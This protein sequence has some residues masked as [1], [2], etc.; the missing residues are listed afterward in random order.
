[1]TES[2]ARLV[3]MVDSPTDS[4]DILEAYEEAVFEQASFFMRRVF[5]PKLAKA[6]VI[7]LEKIELAAKVLALNVAS[8]V[9]SAVSFDFDCAKNHQDVLEVY[10]LAEMKI[11]L[12]L[13]NS[14]SASEAIAAFHSWVGLFDAYMESFLLLCD[15]EDDDSTVKLTV[16][17]IFVEFKN[18]TEQEKLDLIR[19]EC[20]RL[21]RLRD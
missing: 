3:L 15:F 11:K 2:E 5:I 4:E 7:K 18:S 9:F 10:N 6:R 13:A 16:A 20:A 17:P 14:S 1:M 12:V 8:K 21:K 19:N